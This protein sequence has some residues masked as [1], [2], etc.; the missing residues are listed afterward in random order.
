MYRGDDVAS[1]FIKIQTKIDLQH[2]TSVVSH[3][4]MIWLICTPM[5]LD[6]QPSSLCV[7]IYI[8]GKSLGSMIDTITCLQ[9]ITDLYNVVDEYNYGDH[10]YSFYELFEGLFH[11]KRSGLL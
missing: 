3:P 8:S 10:C 4:L 9:E 6:L 5:P 2:G 7:Y 1:M 11:Y